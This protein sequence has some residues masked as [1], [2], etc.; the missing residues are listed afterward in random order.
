VTASNWNA[1]LDRLLVEKLT[2]NE[3]R[4]AL[5]VARLTLG[6]R[7]TGRHLGR[8][9]IREEAG[10]MDGRSFARGLAGLVDKG[11]IHYQAGTVGRGNRG[12]YELALGSSE[13]AAP[14]RPI[15]GV[16]K[17]APARPKAQIVKGRSG[18]M[19]KAAP[20][21]PRRGKGR[22][23]P[24][25]ATPGLQSLVADAVTAYRSHG[26]SLDLENRRL[27]LAGSVARLARDGYD[28]RTILAAC[29]DLGRSNTFPGSLK[30]RADEITTQG[31]PCLHHG[32][33]HGL[34]PTQ[35]LEC[36]CTRCTEWAEALTTGATT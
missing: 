34:T 4:V 23:K 8:K 9:W 6:Y 22:V 14:A 16:E 24:S 5:A 27:A 31:G 29:S 10:N 33:R 35:L 28:K 21:R 32:H 17:A 26:G 30:Q 7:K 20:Q 19:K 18:G 12:Y 1:F 3:H 15:E 25:P 11:L 36:G 2:V 13:K